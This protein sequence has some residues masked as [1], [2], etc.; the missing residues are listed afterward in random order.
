MTHAETEFVVFCIEEMAIECNMSG[1]D[2]YCLLAEKTDMIK[3]YIV[4]NYEILHSMG[5]DTIIE[6]LKSLLRERGV[7][8]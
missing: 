3:N 1:N 4:P 8:L 5:R 6:E 7:I 2:M